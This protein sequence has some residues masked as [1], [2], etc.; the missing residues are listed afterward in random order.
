MSNTEIL[1]TEC[2][3]ELDEHTH[4]SLINLAEF[5]AKTHCN[6]YGQLYTNKNKYGWFE[7]LKK[8]YVNQVAPLYV[9]QGAVMWYSENI[10]K[11]YI[12][13]ISRPSEFAFKWIKICSAK[14]RQDSDKVKQQNKGLSYI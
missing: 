7:T 1:R 11:K 4:T 9:L 8:M 12:P 13:T 6:H 14:I 2:H 5:I 3:L 10:G